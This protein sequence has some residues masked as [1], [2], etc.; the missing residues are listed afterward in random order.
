MHFAGL[1]RVKFLERSFDKPVRWSNTFTQHSTT[2]MKKYLAI[3][4]VAAFAAVSYAGDK[5][6]TQSPKAA[7]ADK[8]KTEACSASV[9]AA[10]TCCADG[11]LAKKD[12]TK[13]IVQS[14]KAAGAAGR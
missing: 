8:A 13:K 7:S 5:A 12:S 6:T 2:T 14:P 11:K 9:A 1:N 4:T 10:S 3:L